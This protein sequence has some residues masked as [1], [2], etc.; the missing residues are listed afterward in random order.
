MW[1]AFFV[2]VATNPEE[3]AGLAAALVSLL[4]A[5]AVA[6][7][8]RAPKVAAVIRSL[9]PFV[10]GAFRAVK[11]PDASTG[12]A[13]KVVQPVI[14]ADAAR[15]IDAD[16]PAAPTRENPKVPPVILTL[17]CVLGLASLGGLASLA[18]CGVSAE[19]VEEGARKL[20]AAATALQLV[21]DGCE[22]GYRQATTPED[23]A[24][25]DALCQPSAD[26]LDAVQVAAAG[27]RG[28]A[29]L[30]AAARGAR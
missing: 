7:E 3:A 27:L 28:A 21:V 5:L 16:A 25:L 18:G 9:I 14:I 11:R 12:P 30:V 20:D 1:R 4:T 22:T 15:L 29:G 10:V 23:L 17:C 2:W 8:G 24:R 26:A 6:L 13:H 19:Q